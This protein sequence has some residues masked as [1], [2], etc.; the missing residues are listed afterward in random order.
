MMSPNSLF[1]RLTSAIWLMQSMTQALGPLQAPS[2]IITNVNTVPHNGSA[3]PGVS[4]VKYHNDPAN[5]LFQIENLDMHPN[6]C[7]M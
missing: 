1:R 7:A 2:Q 6:P 3:V 4:P 5:D